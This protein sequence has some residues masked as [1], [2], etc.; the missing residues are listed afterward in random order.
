MSFLPVLRRVA[1]VGALTMLA[2]CRQ[3]LSCNHPF[4][5]PGVSS[6]VAFVQDPSNASLQYVVE[7]GGTIRVIQNGSAPGDTVCDHLAHRH[8]RRARPA[9]PRLPPQLRLEPPVLRVLH[10]H[11]RRHRRLAHAAIRRQPARVGRIAVRSR[12]AGRAGLHPASSDQPQRR[13]HRVRSR[14]LPLY[15]YRRRRRR[16]RPGSQR[17]EPG[18]AARQ[19]AADRRLGGG[20]RRRRLQRAGRQP[21]R[22]PAGL[23]AARSGASA[24][25]THGAGAST[26]RRSEARARSSSATSARAHAKRSTTSRRG[27]ADATTAGATARARSTPASRRTCRR[28]SCRS[29]IRSSTT[30][31]AS[32][33]SVTG[34]F[35]YRGTALGADVSRALFLCGLRCR[36]RLVA[37][38][39]DRSRHRRS[40]GLGPRRAHGGARRHRDHRQH[41]RVRCRRVGRALPGELQ[42]IDP[43]HR[44]RD[45]PADA[46]DEYRPPRQRRGRAPAVHDRRLGARCDGADRNGDHDPARVGL[47]RRPGPRRVSSASQGTAARGRMSAAAFGTANSRHPVSESRSPGSQPGAYQFM[48]FGWVAALNGFN[49]V[50]SVDVTIGSSTLLVIDVPRHLS[51]V[52]RT[53]QLAGWTFDSSAPTGTGH[54]HDSRVGLPRRGRSAELCRSAVV[55]TLTA[56]RRRVLRQPLHAERLQHVGVDA[57]AGHV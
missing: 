2:A 37:G 18:H 43:P 33:Q 27:A 6:P 29:P 36:P 55:R 38:A 52:A 42:R 57:D 28:P 22:G 21:V 11:E 41:R 10:Q 17:A 26:T 13:Q 5:Y 9:R 25:A 12:V 30:A 19:D 23:P 48:V 53:F 39:V 3:A 7:L 31:A 46:A 34:G 40:H 56:G 47:P 50:R 49:V 14:R 1:A 51:T 20:R 24:G 45:P 4:M 32:G 35:V 8:R 54:R 44:P 15:R 16:Q